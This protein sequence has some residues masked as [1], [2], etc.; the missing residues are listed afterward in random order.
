M[1]DAAD[2]IGRHLNIRPPNLL[3][4]MRDEHGR[5]KPRVFYLVD[6]VNAHEVMAVPSIEFHKH[7]L[8]RQAED[9]RRN[10]DARR[11]VNAHHAALNTLQMTG[12][13]DTP[14][15]LPRNALPQLTSIVRQVQVGIAHAALVES[16]AQLSVHTERQA[17]VNGIGSS[18]FAIATGTNRSTR[19]HIHA[20]ISAL[21]MFG[22]CPLGQRRRYHLRRTSR[23]KTAH[24][25]QLTMLNQPSRFGRRHIYHKRRYIYV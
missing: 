19:H 15:H 11:Q 24:S 1:H 13:N 8:A 23:T 2:A 12:F 5:A 18:Q 7:A 25:Q 6:I 9:G 4:R 20:K 21:S 14:I 22:P 17:A 10:A 16:A 3:H